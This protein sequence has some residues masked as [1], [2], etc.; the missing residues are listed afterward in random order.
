MRILYVGDLSRGGTCYQ[1]YQALGDIGHLM[2][3][4]SSSNEKTLENQD[5]FCKRIFRRAFGLFD[6]ARANDQLLE[7]SKRLNFD[8]LWLDKALTIKASTIERFKERNPGAKV[9]GY[10]P[11]DMFSPHNHSK[12]FLE[13]LHL[14]DIYFT[15][16][17]Y[18]VAELESLGCP[19]ACFIGNAF[20]PSVHRPVD[21]PPEHKEI[22]GGPVGFIGTWE[23]ERSASIHFLA[24]NGV[25]VRVWGTY[26][27]KDKR[28]D[29]NVVVENRAVY[30]QEYATAICSFD[31][32]LCFLRKKN[33]DLQTTRSVEIP[34]CGAF[35]LAERSPEHLE[36]FEEG[37]E[38]EFF[39]ANDELFL[40][41]KYYL[42]HP[43][44][45]KKIASAGRR[46]CLESGYSNHMRLQQMLSEVFSI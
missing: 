42:G 2:V 31:I 45:R 18:G 37:K 25:K 40:K 9:C 43:D 44:E 4:I 20:D 33:R 21:V 32:N 6:L 39:S 14:Y 38:A 10:S 16:K 26:W 46:R 3:P 28:K 27:W 30:G 29:E 11:D 36:L 35:M 24:R 34:A 22:L 1:R 19:R 13:H 41:I 8:V 17:S 7:V 23:P 5:D 15:T 12:R